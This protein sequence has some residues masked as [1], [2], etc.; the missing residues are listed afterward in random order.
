MNNI[1]DI[2]NNN[3]KELPV[4]IN[5]KELIM[6]ILARYSAE[7]TVLRELTQ[8]SDD[9]KSTIINLEINT[10]KKE[11]RYRNNGIT[12]TEN[13][14]TRVKTIAQGNPDSNTVGC[15]GVG[16]YSVF[17]ITNSPIIISGKNAMRF[18]FNNNLLNT[19]FANLDEDNTDTVFIFNDVNDDI[20]KEWTNNKYDA[21]CEYLKRNI[22]FTKYINKII[23]SIKGGKEII[24]TKTL[25]ENSINFPIQ[26]FKYEKK[27]LLTFNV[28]NIK[29]NLINLHLSNNPNNQQKLII[30]EIDINI[31][32]TKL[33]NE[34]INSIMTKNFPD[35]TKLK[36]IYPSTD[37]QKN[38]IPWYEAFNCNYITDLSHG[39][40]YIGFSTQ[41]TTGNGFDIEGQFVPTVERENMD[42]NDPIISVWNYG[43]LEIA[44]F[45]IRNFY[46]QYIIFYKDN[47]N[48]LANIMNRFSFQK[49]TPDNRV[50]NFIKK[51]FYH[52]YNIMLPCSNGIQNIKTIKLLP[53]WLS[54]DDLYQITNNLS[55]KLNINLVDK[56][57]F[58][59]NNTMY[60]GLPT[61]KFSEL[62]KEISNFDRIKL[63]KWYIKNIITNK[64]NR[65]NNKLFL[66][67]MNINSTHF[68]DKEY[69]NLPLPNYIINK[70]ISE[71]LNDQ[72]KNIIGFKK[73]NFIEWFHFISNSHYITDS[74]Y[75]IQIMEF[76]SYKYFVNKIFLF[77]YSHNASYLLLDCSWCQCYQYHLLYPQH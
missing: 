46:D 69:Y 39:H 3:I 73:I 36:L 22:L 47:P 62:C 57:S 15:F 30:I 71:I 29:K 43:L 7:F 24:I 37:N 33:F 63:I 34:K 16:F 12:F 77:K 70:D 64:L 11:I 6:K 25:E 1:D 58:T 32:R 48:E 44:G 75:N 8:N 42:L 45:V 4:E 19:T 68:I 28:H 21:L 40:I 13:D 23:F 76:I 65:S 66:K 2:F 27:N 20:L 38:K 52:N 49:S 56:L 51:G 9:A 18:R 61:L 72:E 55:N 59:K 54:I 17:S 35:K 5:Q 31:K 60:N 41:Q 67:S 53:K 50:S 10:E 14:W 26:L 74:K